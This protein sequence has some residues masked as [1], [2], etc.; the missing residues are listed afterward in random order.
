MP[1]KGLALRILKRDEGGVVTERTSE[2]HLNRFSSYLT[3]NTAV[4]ADGF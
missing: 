1:L 2:V 4:N 3:G